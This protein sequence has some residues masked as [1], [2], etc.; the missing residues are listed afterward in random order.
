MPTVLRALNLPAERRRLED[1]YFR[2]GRVLFDPMRQLKVHDLREAPA[3]EVPAIQQPLAMV[4]HQVVGDDAGQVL[5]PVLL[6]GNRGE[7]P[8]V[9]IMHALR[10]QEHRM[11]H[12]RSS[13]RE[14]RT[15]TGAV[16]QPK[17]GPGGRKRRGCFVPFL[18]STAGW[19]PATPAAAAARLHPARPSRTYDPC[20]CAGC[21]WARRCRSTSEAAGPTPLRRAAPGGASPGRFAPR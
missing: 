21:D 16:E 10:G 12:R 4:S 3:Q 5:H 15:S 17:R 20:L 14:T 13:K 1:D 19:S 18:P 6:I 9:V 7:H 2:K 8:Q 11:S